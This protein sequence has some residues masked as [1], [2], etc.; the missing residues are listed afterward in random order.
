MDKQI[1]ITMRL[2]M[3]C[4]WKLTLLW[5][6]LLMLTQLGRAALLPQPPAL[7]VA[8]TIPCRGVSGDHEGAI[9]WYT[10]GMGAEPINSGH[11]IPWNACTSIGFAYYYIAS[12]D[13]AGID[14]ASSGGIRGLDPVAGFPRLTAALANQGYDIGQLKARYTAMNLGAD[15]QGQDWS[16]DPNTMTEVRRYRGGT[17]TFTLDGQPLVGGAMPDFYMAIQYALMGIPCNDRISGYTDTVHPV[18]QS[19]ASPAAV[20]AVAA[21]LLQDIGAG[22]LR[23]VYDSFQPA[24]QWEYNGGSRHGAFFDAQVGHLELIQ[25]TTLSIDDVRIVENNAAWSEAVF[26]VTLSQACAQDVRVDFSTANGTAQAGSDYNVAAGTLTVQAGQLSGTIRVTVWG[27]TDVEPDETFFVN[28]SNPVNAVITDPQGQGIILNDDQELPRVPQLSINDVSLQEGNAGAVDAVFTVSLSVASAQESTVDYATANGTAQSDSDFNAVAGT[29]RIPAN[30]MSGEIRVPV[31]GDLAVEPDEFF[32]V[33][34]NNAVNAPILDGQG[35]GTIRNDDQELPTLSINDVTVDEGNAGLVSVTFTVVLSRIS[36]QPVRLRYATSNG[37]AVVGED[38][39]ESHGDLLIPEGQLS[40]TLNVLVRGDVLLEPDE[41]FL[42]TLT[43]PV[44]ATLLRDMGIGTIRNDDQA[45]ASALSISD[46]SQ[47]EGPDGISNLVFTVTLWPP[48][49]QE[50]SVEYRTTSDTAQWGADYA[51]GNGNLIFMPGETNRTLPVGVQGDLVF[52]PDETFFVTLT[53]AVN[54]TLARAQAVGTILNDDQELP[55]SAFSVD[56]AEMLEGDSGFAPMQFTLTLWP[57]SSQTVRI[58]FETGD[59]TAQA[60]TDFGNSSGSLI[61]LAGQTNTTLTVNIKGDTDV[62]P[63]ETFFVNLSNPQGAIVARGQGIGTILN[64][65]RE[66]PVLPA[67]VVDDVSVSEG[68]AGLVE[69]IFP[70]HLSAPSTVAVAVDFATLDGTALAGSDY[71]DTHGT[72]TLPPGVTNAVITVPV[73]GDRDV[74]P[75]EEYFYLNLSNVTNATLA[76]AQAEGTISSDERPPFEEGSPPES[77][78]VCTPLIMNRDHTGVENWFVKAADGDLTIRFTAQTVN[79]HDPE[80]VRGRVYDA[81]GTLLVETNVSYTSVE[82]ALH[83]FSTNVEVTLPARLAGEILR[84][85]VA[86]PPPTPWTQ[87]HYRLRFCGAVEAGL[88]SPSFRGFEAVPAKWVFHVR[89]GEDL[90][91]DVF[92][93]SMPMPL[94]SN[95]NLALVNPAGSVVMPPNLV[96][97]VP[98]LEIDIP[99]ALPGAWTLVVFPVPGADGHYRLDKPTGAD[100][101]IYVNWRSGGSAIKGGEIYHDGQLATGKP[102]TVTLTPRFGNE[103][104]VGTNSNSTDTRLVQHTMNGTF[105]FTDLPAGDYRVEVQ[106]SQPGVSTPP[107]QLDRFYCD[108]IHTNRFDTETVSVAPSI[109]LQ[110]ARQIEGNSGT[111]EAFFL[112][113]LSAPSDQPISVHFATMDDTAQ[114]GDDYVASSGVLAFAP[115]ERIKAIPVIINGDTVLETNEVFLVNLDSPIN[116]TLVNTQAVGVII[117][118]D[119]QPALRVTKTSDR[120]VA[121]PDQSIEFLIQAENVGGAVATGVSIQDFLPDGLQFRDASVPPGASFNPAHIEWILPQLAPQE[122][123]E[124]RLYAQVASAADL[125]GLFGLTTAPGSKGPPLIL[126]NE[127]GLGANRVT[128]TATE[129][130]ENARMGATAVVRLVPW[131]LARSARIRSDGGFEFEVRSLPEVVLMVQAS[132]DLQNWVTVRVYDPQSGDRLFTEAE[133]HSRPRRFFRVVPQ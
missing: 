11:A 127:Y 133:S 20:Q 21:A 85:E 54:A 80:M 61:F 18:D 24:T 101:G 19:Q 71:A 6:G 128:V 83:P 122:K 77:L 116:A 43:N 53:N 98:G 118:D 64:D 75:G 129:L 16:Y 47:P 126:R 66:M 63:N 92:T 56:D 5:S 93:N 7:P 100:R 26:T 117:N 111:T 31:L 84:V 86:T 45:V 123:V 55:P 110:E 32:F 91:V 37:T 104:L 99:G 44:N 42:V 2:I 4:S 34:L 30:Q 81:I 106:S 109:Y 52:E 12:R 78:C 90:R 132:D 114:A 40:T 46:A 48:N 35:R 14:P 15:V 97:I 79:N 23:F 76:R 87:S 94:A 27:D 17:F 74:E 120:T 108:D 22:E 1:P 88:N 124:L 130:P 41:T 67:L 58:Q 3:S 72:L 49:P 10:D 57:P 33:E 73:I 62:E 60:G 121:T 50:V 69:A 95:L 113:R 89:P 125:P 25:R 103:D 65:D 112:A 8:G 70:V 102:Y 107:P 119:Q 13:Y 51:G 36:D 82:A 68:D 28:L 39:S 131:P 9:A 59:N 96:P 105:E 115:G 38:Y 29:L